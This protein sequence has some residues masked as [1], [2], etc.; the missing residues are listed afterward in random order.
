V[1]EVLRIEQCIDKSPEASRALD[2]PGTPPLLDET[3]HDSL[4]KLHEVFPEIQQSDYPAKKLDTTWRQDPALLISS[5]A[6]SSPGIPIL[7]DDTYFSEG[8]D[9]SRFPISG[10]LLEA[11]DLYLRYA[12]RSVGSSGHAATSTLLDELDTL[13]T[14][15]FSDQQ[16]LQ[17][18]FSHLG[19]PNGPFRRFDRSSLLDEDAQ[20]QFQRL[21]DLIMITHEADPRYVKV[22]CQGSSVLTQ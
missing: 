19:R 15:P 17:T 5:D 1:G 4:I 9:N 21:D 6:T 16:S 22:L 14:F 7:E 13:R 11:F 8:N 10:E 3:D 20:L 2:R 18:A 12:I